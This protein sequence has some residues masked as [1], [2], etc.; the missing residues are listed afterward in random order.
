MARRMARVLRAELRRC[1]YS[2]HDNFVDDCFRA[3]FVMVKIELHLL[4]A[5]LARL[6]FAAEKAF[7]KMCSAKDIK[8][9]SRRPY[10]AWKSATLTGS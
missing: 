3:F 6:R 2:I 5:A 7:Q 9:I 1:R 4:I 8:S 10:R